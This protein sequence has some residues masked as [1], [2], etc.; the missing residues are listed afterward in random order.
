M[1]E[2]EQLEMNNVAFRGNSVTISCTDQDRSV[3]FYEAILGAERLPRDQHVCPWFRLGMLTLSLMQNAA[4]PSPAV[5]P[6]HAMPILWLEVDNLAEA[7]QHLA[8]HGV[9]IT[10]YHDDLMLICVDPDGLVIE[11]WQSQP[12]DLE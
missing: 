11:V 9:V 2:G 12:T 7:N 8:H 1:N 5:F 4:E 3:R 10:E 6:S